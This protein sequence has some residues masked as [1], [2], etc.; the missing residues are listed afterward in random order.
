MKSRPL[1]KLEQT[2][3]LVTEISQN[4]FSKNITNIGLTIPGNCL[5]KSV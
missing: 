1:L 5:S 4:K 3:R 2:E